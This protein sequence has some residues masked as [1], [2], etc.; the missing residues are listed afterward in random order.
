MPLDL[1]FATQLDEH[2][3]GLGK[4]EGHTSDDRDIFDQRPTE[5]NDVR[6]RRRQWSQFEPEHLIH[7]MML[8]NEFQQSVHETKCQYL[9]PL[10][11]RL[12][13]PIQVGLRAK[14]QEQVSWRRSPEKKK[15][16]RARDASGRTRRTE[17]RPATKAC[18]PISFNRLTSNAVSSAG[19]DTCSFAAEGAM[20]K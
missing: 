4:F 8:H 11:A 12:L 13:L 16:K 20:A 18:F 5:I 6:C 7:T 2:D 17:F 19:V 3:H 14:G 9:R 15:I 1:V 10:E